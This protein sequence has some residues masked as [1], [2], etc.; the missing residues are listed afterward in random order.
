MSIFLPAQVRSM[1]SL[2]TWNFSD[3]IWSQGIQTGKDLFSK[4][5][6]NLISQAILPSSRISREG[7]ETRQEQFINGI[8]VKGEC[9]SMI[10]SEDEKS[11]NYFFL[12]VPDYVRLIIWYV[13]TRKLFILFGNLRKHPVMFTAY[14][15]LYT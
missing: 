8:K 3:C 5:L 15:W 7:I 9:L 12:L 10:L 2:W 6:E 1:T 4:W 11:I 13:G 14:S